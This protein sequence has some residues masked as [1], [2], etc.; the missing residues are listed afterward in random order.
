MEAADHHGKPGGAELAGEIERAGKLV[1]LHA[2]QADEAGFGTADLANGALDVDD[3]VALVIG[4]DVD[5]AR[6]NE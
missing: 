1:G 2:D 3:G 6:R 5:R 4:L